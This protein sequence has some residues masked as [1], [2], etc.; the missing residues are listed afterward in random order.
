MSHPHE[1][2]PAALEQIG[3]LLSTTLNRA[4]ISPENG[5]R[6]SWAVTVGDGSWPT[7]SQLAVGGGG[8]GGDHFESE[9]RYTH[10]TVGA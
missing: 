3:H 1:G 4:A 6:F 10:S 8:G 7:P 5:T 9:K 2:I